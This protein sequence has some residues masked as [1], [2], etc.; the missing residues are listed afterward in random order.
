MLPERQ[1]FGG[2]RIG[3]TSPLIFT[4]RH[5]YEMTKVAFGKIDYPFTKTN[6]VKVLDEGKSK[7][8]ANVSDEMIANWCYEFYLA[9][10]E[11]DDAQGDLFPAELAKKVALDVSSQWEADV[12]NTNGRV[13]TSDQYAM[14]IDEL[15]VNNA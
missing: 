9:Y 15:G 12:G 5:Q 10:N 2:S 1:N 14:W 7:N 3:A 11:Y 13:L 6:L 8:E 4:V